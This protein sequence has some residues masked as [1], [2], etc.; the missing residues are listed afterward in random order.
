MDLLINII[1]AIAIFLIG[2]LLLMLLFYCILLVGFAII[3]KIRDL[4]DYY[5]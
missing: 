3:E 4:L 2:T 1:L 5:T